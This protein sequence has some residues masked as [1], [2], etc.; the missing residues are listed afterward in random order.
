MAARLR[1]ITKALKD[2]GVVVTKPKKGSHWK[3][4]RDG[5]TYPIPAHNG[6]KSEISDAYIRGLCDC[7]GIDEK[8][9]RAKL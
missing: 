4:Q 9:F 5:K 7:F 8:E 3:A 1:D 6:E 2:F